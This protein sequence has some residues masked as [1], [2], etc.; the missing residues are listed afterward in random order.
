MLWSQLT[1]WC[2]VITAKA[3]RLFCPPD[4]LVIGRKANSPVTPYRPK[5]VRYS[6]SNFPKKKH[7]VINLENFKLR[8][9]TSQVRAQWSYF[10]LIWFFEKWT[11]V[12]TLFCRIRKLSFWVKVYHLKTTGVSW[13]VKTLE[14]VKP[15]AESLSVNKINNISES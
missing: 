4:K 12:Y 1:Y 13:I 9:K 3:T 11:L 10:D 7:S 5:C 14:N 6:T 2:Q 15:F 8:R